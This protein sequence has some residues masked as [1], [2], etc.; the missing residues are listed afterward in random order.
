MIKKVFIIFL[1]LSIILTGNIAIVFAVTTNELKN[2]QNNLDSQIE[3]KKDEIE[4]IETQKSA[5]MTEVQALTAEISA[6]QFE[7]ENLNTELKEVE[8]K[9][10]ETEVRL[11]EAEEKCEE[12]NEMMQKRLVALYEAGETNY[13]DILLNSKDVSNFVTNYYL[14]S[15]IATI[16]AELLQQLE[17]T[18]REI[19]EAKRVLDESRN[20]ISNIKAE[21]ETKANQLVSVQQ[22]K[23]AKIAGLNN[24]ERALQKEIDQYE[25][26]KL[27]LQR[28]INSIV[29][30][31]KAK[32]EREKKNKISSSNSTS[33][34]TSRSNSGTSSSSNLGNSSSQ[35]VSSRVSDSGFIFPV[36]GLSTGNI[37]NKSYP[38]YPGHTGTD[39]N[40]NTVGK[41][42]VAAKGGTVVISTALHGDIPTYNSSGA[43][44]G[45]YRSYGEYILIN[46]HDGTMTLY[47][48]LYPGSRK[49]SSGQSVSQGQVIGTV[50]NTG[51]CFPRPTASSP[52]NGTHL[53]FEVRVNGTCVNPL[54]YL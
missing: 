28:Q 21:K 20:K 2:K 36:Q 23:Q 25:N 49:V 26:D 11:K 8:A 12:Q 18:K 29:A 24:E 9:I 38:S 45:S 13:L 14:V 53:H 4:Q 32:A 34:T 52:Y 40:I 42:V 54:R 15:E 46:H 48:H 17:N 39:I 50:G 22:A 27:D 43:Y 1:V 35:P 30:E 10:S 3:E 16:D 19:E 47:G 31:E 51:N 7:I 6:Y 33:T 37:S 5:I 41:N 44:L